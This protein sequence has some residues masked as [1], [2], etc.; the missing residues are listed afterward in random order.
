MTELIIRER[1][2]E[3]DYLQIA[4]VKSNKR[5]KE[6]LWEGKIHIKERKEKIKTV[7]RYKEK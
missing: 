3:K 5:K 4:N 1:S 2:L 6:E 7:K